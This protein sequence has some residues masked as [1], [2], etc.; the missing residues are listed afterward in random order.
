MEVHFELKFYVALFY[1]LS[2][3]SYI[4]LMLNINSAWTMFWLFFLMFGDLSSR[5]VF[6]IL[7]LVLQDS[8]AVIG[9]TRSIVWHQNVWFFILCFEVTC[10]Y[11]NSFLNYLRFATKPKSESKYD[12]T[13]PKKQGTWNR[14]T[15]LFLHVCK[16]LHQ[17]NV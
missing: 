3:D 11:L 9:N 17:K 12:K 6:G 1:L 4:H 8:K 16:I 10:S 13:F 5:S 14:Y 2:L 15:F 7:Y